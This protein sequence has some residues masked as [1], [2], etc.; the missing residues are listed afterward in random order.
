VV[1]CMV[2]RKAFELPSIPCRPSSFSFS[3]GINKRR[4]GSPVAQ[5]DLQQSM[6]WKRIRR[7]VSRRRI[8]K[9]RNL[10]SSGLWEE[11]GTFHAVYY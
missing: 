4:D 3:Y 9:K 5:Y 11:E 10:R 1:A 8:Y 6:V 7:R 2:Y